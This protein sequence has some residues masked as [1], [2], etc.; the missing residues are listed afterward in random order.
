MLESKGTLRDWRKQLFNIKWK[1]PRNV[2]SFNKVFISLKCFS[3]H[4]SNLSSLGLLPP[5]WLS[6]RAASL[7]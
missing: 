1:V 2:K 6:H 7:Y 3:L 5:E 4:I